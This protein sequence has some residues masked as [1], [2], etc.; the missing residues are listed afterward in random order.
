MLIGCEVWITR[1]VF[2]RDVGV[3][4]EALTVTSAGRSTRSAIEVALLQH[5]DDGVRLLRGRHHADRLVLVRVE[6]AR[7]RRVDLDHLVALER[8][9]QLAQ[10]RVDALEQLL[11]GGRRNGDRRFEA[12]LAPAAGSRRS[13]RPRTC[14]PWPSLPRRGGGCSRPRPWRA[15]R[16]R[17]A[18]RGGPRGRP[19]PA[20]AAGGRG[21]RVSAAACC[22]VG[23]RWPASVRRW[24]RS[25]SSRRT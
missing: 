17:T 23:S 8:R 9:R 2:K 3:S 18:R 5:R 10:R 22:R 13:S 12:V 19:A 16:R 7:R 6:A 15:G 11:G 24:G 1:D 4:C 21:R 20:P 14:A 25:R